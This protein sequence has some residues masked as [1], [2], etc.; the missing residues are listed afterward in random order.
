MPFQRCSRLFAVYLFT[1]LKVIFDYASVLGCT[2]P[3]WYII[4]NHDLRIL[5]TIG[6]PTY[7]GSGIGLTL[8]PSSS[9][10]RYPGGCSV[11]GDKGCI[12]PSESSPFPPRCL[13][14][15]HMFCIPRKGAAIARLSLSTQGFGL[16][17]SSVK[18]GNHTKIIPDQI[19]LKARIPLA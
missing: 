13:R 5:F 6:I 19:M 2:L 15:E 10:K 17:I 1:S 4:V 18:R 7:D 12:S 16:E 14:P 8:I 11:S 3:D 9:S